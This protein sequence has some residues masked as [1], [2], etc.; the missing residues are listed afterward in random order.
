[1]TET[2]NGQTDLPAMIDHARALRERYLADPHRPGYHLMVPEGAHGPVDPN[3]ALFWNGRYHL[4]YI[5]QHAGKHY[6][7]H[8][9][10]VDLVHW[11]HHPP[12]LGPGEGDDG[13]FS[14]G[15]FI[16]RNG[17]ATITYWR[18][19]NPDGIAIATSTDPNLDHWTKSPHNPV[20]TSTQF[21]WAE[22]PSADGTGTVVYGT[23]DPSAIWSHNG[24]Y[25]MLTGNL[26]VLHEFGINRKQPERQGDTTYLFVSDNL[27][28]W[29]YL[30]EFYKSDRKWTRADEDD[31]CPDFFPL[32][33]SPDGGPATD[34]HMLLFISHNLGCQY[35]LGS[36]AN[37]RF[38]PDMHGRMTW[39]DKEFFAPESLK[40][41]NGRRIMWS[42]VFDT[43][44]DATKQASGWSGEMSLPRL[45]WVGED[46]TLRLRPVPELERLR[47]N[48][49]NRRKSVVP[50]DVT[51]DVPKMAGNSIELDIE[52]EPCAAAQ[53]GVKVCRSPDGEEETAVLYDAS[54]HAL[55]IDTRKSSLG[56]GGKAVE[57]AP[58]TLAP[59]ESLHLRV[60]VDKSFVE[61]FAN[62]R[63]AVC[64]RIYPTRS[65]SLGVALCAVGGPITVTRLRAWD[66][67]PSNPY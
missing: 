30:H 41:P 14:G 46:G 67:M 60:F 35:Y 15:A 55:K 19:G 42:W 38:T 54:E 18:L 1:M 52:I 5:Y 48:P 43:R 58:F 2:K 66:M 64:R 50:A 10:S 53:C 13:I 33:A 65:D 44:T 22:A 16:D 26:L 57:S 4:C 20:L 36:Y 61:V 32:P 21:G 6:W 49:R 29:T 39:V 47:H 27:V 31:M 3:G 23:A 28:H 12:A 56:E 62:D 7:G 11:R 51:V 59:G 8:A 40:D 34:R 25:Y 37:D 24:R 17:V 9:S 45:L 63:Q